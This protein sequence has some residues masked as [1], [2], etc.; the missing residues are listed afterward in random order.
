MKL[1]IEWEYPKLGT[2]NINRKNMAMEE[3]TVTLSSAATNPKP[4]W[5]CTWEWHQHSWKSMSCTILYLVLELK[6]WKKVSFNLKFLHLYI[7]FFNTTLSMYYFCI[8]IALVRKLQELFMNPTT[9]KT[10]DLE[11]ILKGQMQIKARPDQPMRA[12]MTGMAK[13]V[14]FMM[15]WIKYI[16]IS[17]TLQLWYIMI[18]CIHLATFCCK[19]LLCFSKPVGCFVSRCCP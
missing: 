4:H 18:L 16:Y 2:E 14:T 8:K 1:I 10:A 5:V 6:E 7:W 17:I 12:C 15:R 19:M 11:K 9:W 13:G 3:N